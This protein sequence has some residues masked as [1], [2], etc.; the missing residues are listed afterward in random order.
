MHLFLYICMEYMINALF[1]KLN[2]EDFLISALSK[3]DEHAFDVIFV[4]YFPK[5]KYFVLN[6]C[7]DENMAENITQ[8]I[9]LNLWVRKQSLADIKNF[10]AYMF[11]IARN[12]A[13]H[14]LK[15][16]LREMSTEV[17]DKIEDESASVVDN[18]YREELEAMINAAVNK[19]PEQRR[20]V[21]VM[22]RIDG[23]SNSE[24]AKTLNI[25][26]RTVETHISLALSELR[27]VLPLILILTLFKRM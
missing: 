15:D 9:F 26:K 14:Y 19:M 22:S 27:K 18:M 17:D 23:L 21:F 12:A 13:L 5:I 7:K 1:A 20:R 11:T 8:D 4:N 6:F 16:S 10:K 2:T 24:I 3:G 25:S